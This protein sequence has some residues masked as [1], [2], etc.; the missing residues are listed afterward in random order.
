MEKIE[1]V[2]FQPSWEKDFYEEQK[3]IKALLPEEVQIYHIGSTAIPNMFARPIIDLMIVTSNIRS[4]DQNELLQTIGYETKGDGSLNRR[5]FV[6]CN[7]KC[8]VH[9][10]VFEKG[11]SEIE[12][13]IAFREYMIAHKEEALEYSE[14]KKSLAEK[15]HED[16]IIGRNDYL[17]KINKQANNWREEEGEQSLK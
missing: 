15:N 6:K 16:Y 11:N 8:R 17:E 3:K 10:H 9:A 1:L 4:F 2:S 5:L 14:L 7:D 12:R 13:H